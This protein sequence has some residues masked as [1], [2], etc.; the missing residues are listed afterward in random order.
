MNSIEDILDVLI[1][2]EEMKSEM[3]NLVPSENLLSFPARLPYLLDINNRYFFNDRRHED[4]W[5]FRG[6]Q[7]AA[8]LETEVAV[9][10]LKKM[11]KANY[12]SVRPVSGIQCMILVLHALGGKGSNVMTL[13]PE[14]GG[15][16]ATASVAESLDMQVYHFRLAP[17]GDVDYEQITQVL[18]DTSIDL[19][20]IDQ[21]NAL[22]P[23]EL[24]P[25]I[26]FFRL[27][28]PQTLIHVD[29]SHFLGFILSGCMDSPLEQGADSFGGSTHKTFPGPQKAVFCTNQTKLALKIKLVQQYMISSHHFGSTI[30]LAIALVEF[31]Q[32]GASF[33]KQIVTNSKALAACLDALGYDVKGKEQGYTA[34]HQIW[35]DTSPKEVTSYEASVR[36]YQS[37]ICVNVMDRLPGSTGQL[38]RI[39]VNEVTMNGAGVEHMKELASIMDSSIRLNVAGKKLMSRVKQLKNKF[40]NPFGF[41]LKEPVLLEK[42]KRL[43][44]LSMN[45]R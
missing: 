3:I 10:L 5:H 12:V 29:S 1:Q 14:D 32:Q 36:L 33:V 21:S 45:R 8:L 40:H 30:S 22:F 9:P 26:R 37:G 41:D 7:H 35:M 44:D 31:K 17:G 38:L 6:G 13:S 27:Y 15:H 39:G 43:M 4:G 28:S 42:C 25:M 34:G 23:L 11:S 16:Y 19:L 2:D 18:Q 20:Y 24:E